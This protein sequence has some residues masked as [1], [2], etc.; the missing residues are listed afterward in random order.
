MVQGFRMPYLVHEYKTIFLGNHFSGKPRQRLKVSKNL[1]PILEFPFEVCQKHKSNIMSYRILVQ[2]FKT[3]NLIDEYKIIFLGKWS[4]SWNSPKL[5]FYI[6][7]SYKFVLKSAKS[8]NPI[9]WATES[10]FKDLKQ[11]MWF[12]NTKPFF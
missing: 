11:R 2:G 4:K 12:T 6:C 3:S 10:W 5:S 1:L 7:V 9:F 8:L